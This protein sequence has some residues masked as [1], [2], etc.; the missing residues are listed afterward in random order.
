MALE[1]KGKERKETEKKKSS[2]LY[3]YLPL[4]VQ[5]VH[6]WVTKLF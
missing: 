1:S 5:G 3:M 6:V 2:Y 4:I